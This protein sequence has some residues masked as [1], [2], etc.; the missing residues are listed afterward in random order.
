MAKPEHAIQ[1]CTTSCT[2]KV[3]NTKSTDKKDY[4]KSNVGYQTNNSACKNNGTTSYN[5]PPRA[6]SP[7]ED[8]T[9]KEADPFI[10]NHCPQEENALPIEERKKK[11]QE[12]KRLK[13]EKKAR[14]IEEKKTKTTGNQKA[15]GSYE[16]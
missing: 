9:L 10:N 1:P 12:E 16:S 2:D 4:S 14:E 6:N 3:E 7:C 5:Q 11:Q 15:K 8:S 13:K